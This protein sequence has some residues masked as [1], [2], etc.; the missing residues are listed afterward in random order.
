MGIWLCYIFIGFTAASFSLVFLLVLNID[1]NPKE[2]SSA[3]FIFIVYFVILAFFTT[4]ILSHIIKFGIR[5]YS[6]HLPSENFRNQNI[7]NSNPAI[8]NHVEPK[9]KQDLVPT[10]LIHRAFPSILVFFCKKYKC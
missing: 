6:S 9:E 5:V 7:E 4:T 2:I 3:C 1:E 10:E 8:P